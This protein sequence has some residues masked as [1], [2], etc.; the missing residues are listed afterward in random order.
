MLQNAAIVA[1]ASPLNIICVL[2]IGSAK[3][4]TFIMM[5][6]LDINAQPRDK[7]PVDIK[8]GLLKIVW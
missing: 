2:D 7:N 4:V 6:A 3:I 5:S 1:P 8:S